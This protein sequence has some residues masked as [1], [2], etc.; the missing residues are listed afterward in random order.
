VVNFDG[1]N[2]DPEYAPL[3]RGLA[4]LTAADLAKV[5]SLRVVERLKIDMLM[6]EL[7][8]GQTDYVDASQAPRMGRML[9]SSK[10]VTGSV[11]NVGEERIRLDGAVVSTRDSSAS[12][13]E[14]SE[15]ELDKFFAVQKELVFKVLG[16]LDVQL[17]ASE[18]DAIQE[19]PTE[20]FLALM[21]FSRGLDFQSRGM[22][23]AAEQEYRQAVSHD[24][25]FAPAQQA[26]QMSASMQAPSVSRAQM[27]TVAASASP[28]EQET[29]LGSRLT[30][31]T[32]RTDDGKT[33]IKRPP[34]PVGTG[35]VVVR[36]NL[37]GD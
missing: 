24:A 10:L 31:M 23:K 5:K 16:D 27:E 33:D 28:G 36:G 26:L 30:W 21:A 32:D 3:A 22:Y 34:T 14:P 37:D 35:T 20:S 6:Q 9:G 17:D 29:S 18:R 13:A 7:K 15:G 4:E 19:F 12:V 2:L 1:S 25:S 11:M 8:L